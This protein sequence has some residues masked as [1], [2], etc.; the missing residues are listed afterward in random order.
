MTQLNKD[1]LKSGW[2][3]V[4]ILVLFLSCSFIIVSSIYEWTCIW[5]KVIGGILSFIA[6]SVSFYCGFRSHMKQN[7]SL[8]NIE[9][10]IK[11]IYNKIKSN[12][13]EQ[14]GNITLTENVC[15]VYVKLT[16]YAMYHAYTNRS[17]KTT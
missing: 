16:L 17:K 4:A 10:L 5:S 6:T 3:W 12:A 9:P 14:I 15:A 8:E 2:F 13:I 7:Q 11:E 1:I